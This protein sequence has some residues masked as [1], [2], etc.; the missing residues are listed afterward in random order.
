MIIKYTNFSDGIHQ[1]KFTEPAEKLG[2]ND[3][4]FGLVNVDCRMDKSVH[5]I[6]LDCCI[7]IDSQMICDRCTAEFSADIN[8]HYTMTYIL[9]KEHEI[10]DEPNFRFLSVEADKIDIRKDVFEY[11]QLAIPMKKLCKDDC[12]GLCPRCGSNLNEKKCG[13]KTDI[14]NDV[15]EPLRKL[16]FN[17]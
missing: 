10:S 13:C 8:S 3:Q 1:I 2:F 9:S 15:W 7:S 6:V 14:S 5:Q 16:K 17:N 4:F 11:I 12:K